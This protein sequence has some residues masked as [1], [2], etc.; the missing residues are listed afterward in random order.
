MWVLDTKIQCI[1][2]DF[3]FCGHQIQFRGGL[4]VYNVL[5]HLNRRDLQEYYASPELRRLL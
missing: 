2:F 3:K 1:P 5:D 4:T